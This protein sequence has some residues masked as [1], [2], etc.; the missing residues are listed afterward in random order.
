[1]VISVF[2]VRI[3]QYTDKEKTRA[4]DENDL[5]LSNAIKTV[6]MVKVK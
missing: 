3:A 6:E 1:M 2:D 5:R 4:R